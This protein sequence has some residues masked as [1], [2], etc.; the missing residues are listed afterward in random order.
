MG[1]G[2]RVVHEEDHFGLKTGMPLRLAREEA[3]YQAMQLWHLV[4]EMS[5]TQRNEVDRSQLVSEGSH[6]GW[7]PDIG[8]WRGGCWCPCG[9]SSL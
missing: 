4:G 5:P 1:A 3:V 2:S 8:T 7:T 9:D 6:Y